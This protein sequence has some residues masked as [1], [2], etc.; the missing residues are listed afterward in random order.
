MDLCHYV[1]YYIVTFQIYLCCCHHRCHHPP[2]LAPLPSPS[3]V[4]TGAKPAEA[5][6]GADASQS[7]HWCCCQLKLTSMPMP[8]PKL[9]L[10]QSY[11]WCRRLSELF[12]L[13]SHVA[14]P[15][16]WPW[17]HSASSAT[18]G[19]A[20]H[21]ATPPRFVSHAA[22]SH[23]GHAATPPRWPCCYS[24][25]LAMLLLHHAGHAATPPRLPC[26]YSATLTMLL[27]GLA[28]NVATPPSWS[29]C[30]FHHF[31][32]AATTRPRW[33]WCHSATLA[34]LLL[35]LVGHAATPTRRPCCYS[36][37]LAV[38]ATLIGAAVTGISAMMGAGSAIRDAVS[39]ALANPN[40]FDLGARRS[41]CCR[42]C[43]GRCS[44]RLESPPRQLHT[45]ALSTAA[46]GS[47]S[48]S[49]RS[50]AVVSSCRRWRRWWVWLSF[51]GRGLGLLRSWCRG[52][53]PCRCC[54]FCCPHAMTAESEA[55]R[56]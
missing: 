17:W 16:R 53:P 26:C 27:L 10:R 13:V 4:I 23:T 7:Y 55:A 5:I 40:G 38:G 14:T 29:C 49:S 18:L 12:G 22:F 42:C 25:W 54:G 47:S 36:A 46:R 34:M 21:D 37:T 52:C 44:G 32:H 9:S 48:G 15:P 50:H 45:K 30:Y 33:P 3:K 41:R 24:A 56:D 31:G 6:I 28:G 2:K 43:C 51:R 19:L 35:G 8:V 20:G 1:S 39:T 11:H